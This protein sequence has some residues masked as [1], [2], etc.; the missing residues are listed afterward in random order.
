MNQKRSL[1]IE[2]SATFGKLEYNWLGG[3]LLKNRKK[4]VGIQTTD[5]FRNL[6]EHLSHQAKLVREHALE[7][8]H[9]NNFGLSLRRGSAYVFCK[10]M[11][12]GSDRISG[13]R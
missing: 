12:K 7:C 3:A 11:R 1:V 10:S 8:K 5:R 2:L 4:N 13:T 6:R 9:L